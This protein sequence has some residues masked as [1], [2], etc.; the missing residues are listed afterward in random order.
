M[1]QIIKMQNITLEK[2][3]STIL[4]IA[5]TVFLFLAL[6]SGWMYFFIMGVCYSAAILVNDIEENPD[7]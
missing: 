3:S 6:F 2:V 5:G 1:K 4:L 7:I